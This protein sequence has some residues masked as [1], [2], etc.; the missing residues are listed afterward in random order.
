M[1]ALA[2]IAPAARLFRVTTTTHTG[3]TQRMPWNRNDQAGFA[4]STLGPLALVLIGNGLI[5]ATGWNVGGDAPDIALAPPGWVIGLIWVVIYPMWGAARWYVW[6]TGLAGRRR[7]RWISALIVWG[8]LYPILTGLTGLIGA[9][10]ANVFS[11]ALACIAAFQAYGVTK[12]GFW[13]IA[14]SLCWIT[15]ATVLGFM[16]LAAL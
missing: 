13:L 10:I 15:F 16:T 2:T 3:A 5:F 11:L 6:Q 4:I 14:P 12:R 7:S 8:L 9:A 1:K